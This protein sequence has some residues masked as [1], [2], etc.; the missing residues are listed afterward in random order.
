MQCYR[1]LRHLKCLSEVVEQYIYEHSNDLR[2]D[3]GL[4]AALGTQASIEDGIGELARLKWSAPFEGSCFGERERV[5]RAFKRGSL[6]PKNVGR[7]W[8]A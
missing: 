3:V 8:R 1:G 2:I 7:R 6:V 5:F 4:R